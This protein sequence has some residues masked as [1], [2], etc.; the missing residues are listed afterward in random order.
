MLDKKLKILSDL[1]AS[2]VW[3]HCQLGDSFVKEKRPCFP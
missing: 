3:F 1:F 2:L